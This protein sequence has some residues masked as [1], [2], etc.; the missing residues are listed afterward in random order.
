MNR[1]I[2]IIIAAFSLTAC[3]QFGPDEIEDTGEETDTNADADTD[4]DSDSDT[5]SDTDADSDAD[6]GEEVEP[7][8]N[9]DDDFFSNGDPICDYSWMDRVVLEVDET[10]PNFRI[11]KDIT[12]SQYVNQNFIVPVGDLWSAEIPVWDSHDGSGYNDA[13]MW[14]L[15]GTRAVTIGHPSGDEVVVAN[16]WALVG[17]DP[18]VQVN[19]IPTDGVPD[20][21]LCVQRPGGAGAVY[22]GDYAECERQVIAADIAAMGDEDPD[23]GDEE[24]EATLWYRDYDEDG[25]GDAGTTLESVEQPDGYVSKSGDCWDTNKDVHP[26]ANEISDKLDNDCDG[27]TD[28]GLTAESIWYRDSDLDG[29]GDVNTTKSAS[30]QPSGYVSDKTDCDDSM[31]SVHPGA[32]EASNNGRDD[33]CN[34][35]TSDPAGP[36][37]DGRSLGTWTFTLDSTAAAMPLNQFEVKNVTTGVSVYVFSKAG[38]VVTVQAVTKSTDV[39]SIQCWLNGSTDWCASNLHNGHIVSATGPSGAYSVGK[40]TGDIKYV[41]DGTGQR[42]GGSVK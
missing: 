10:N 20:V 4:A 12:P 8:P 35:A 41:V 13:T 31:A 23:T 33:D 9:G 6:T 14:G 25:F 42:Y 1:S 24:P 37:S 17:I 27:Q 2:S 7:C 39:L 3:G 21:Y 15:N 38:S 36:P 34:P 22:V 28:E 19:P 32:A 11:A 29:Y 5:D 26:G 18:A 16:L 40:T 30:T